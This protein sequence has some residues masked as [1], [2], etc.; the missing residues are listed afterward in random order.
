MLSL[1]KETKK[2][3]QKVIDMAREYF[4]KEGVGLEV[5]NLGKNCLL[6]E[7]GGGYVQ[8]TACKDNGTTQ[9]DVEA[10]EYDFHAKRFLE[11]I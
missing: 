7:G 11:K 4:G 6:S 5:K 3:P 10:R 2:E 1:R 9:V 8:V